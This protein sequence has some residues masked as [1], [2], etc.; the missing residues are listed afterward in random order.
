[1]SSKEAA[2]LTDTPITDYKDELVPACGKLLNNMLSLGVTRRV[3]SMA[4]E[5]V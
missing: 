3:R 2:R 4:S 1:M 5:G